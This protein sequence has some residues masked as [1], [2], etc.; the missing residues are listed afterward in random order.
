MLSP[1]K[2]IAQGVT[3]TKA[4]Q[5]AGEYVIV[6]EAAHHRGFSHGFN[7]A[8]AVNWADGGGGPASAEASRVPTSST[9]SFV[10]GACSTSVAVERLHVELH[11]RC[12]A[13]SCRS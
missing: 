3:V 2:L 12:P 13:P 1:G 9:G 5:H 7:V 11:D 4:V 8:E 6:F 10:H